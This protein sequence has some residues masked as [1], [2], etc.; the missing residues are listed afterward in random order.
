[1]ATEVVKVYDT[2][3]FLWKVSMNAVLATH[4][5]EKVSSWPTNNLWALVSSTM[6]TI[7]SDQVPELMHGY[8]AEKLLDY[9]RYFTV[10]SEDLQ[11][12]EPVQDQ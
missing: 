4:G 6:L 11:N 8:G 10:L 12:E 1:M 3:H 5:K 2:G 9:G 7:K